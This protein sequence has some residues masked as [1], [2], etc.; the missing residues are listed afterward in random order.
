M[1]GIIFVYL[2]GALG[3]RKVWKQASGM[4]DGR[5]RIGCTGRVFGK[6]RKDKY[7]RCRQLESP[8]PCTPQEEA[9]EEDRE[10]TRPFMSRKSQNFS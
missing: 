9:V 2:S 6:D 4:P 3:K 5:K 8:L 7:F 10:E 1:A